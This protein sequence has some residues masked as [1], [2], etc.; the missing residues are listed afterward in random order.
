M[1]FHTSRFDRPIC[2]WT[3]C[4]AEYFTFRREHPGRKPRDYYD[5]RT[6]TEIPS[7]FAKRS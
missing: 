3:G 5:R 4:A 1:R 2:A 6:W 7:A